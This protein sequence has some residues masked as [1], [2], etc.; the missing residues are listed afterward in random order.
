MSKRLENYEIFWL[1]IN[2]RKTWW[3]RERRVGGEEE[4]NEEKCVEISRL[5]KNIKDIILFLGYLHFS[6]S[7]SQSLSI[8]SLNFQFNQFSPSLLNIPITKNFLWNSKFT[9]IIITNLFL[10]NI[11]F[12]NFVQS[13][14]ITNVTTKVLK[15]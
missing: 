2:G 11:K 15:P 13:Y 9:L 6:H 12:L 10:I 4:R 8:K 1:G 3:R 5:L 7:S 14:E